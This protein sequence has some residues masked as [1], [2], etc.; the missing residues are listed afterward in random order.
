VDTGSIL[1]QA[2]PGHSLKHSAPQGSSAAFYLTATNMP[3]PV[4]EL[5]RRKRAHA[6]NFI[7]AD[8]VSLRPD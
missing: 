7:A 4:R 5:N 6:L 8:L 1:T 3:L 2:P